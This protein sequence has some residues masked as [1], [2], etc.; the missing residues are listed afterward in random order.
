[1]PLRQEW[2]DWEP[3]YEGVEGQQLCAGRGSLTRLPYGTDLIHGRTEAPGVES[4][5]GSETGKGEMLEES[6]PSL[7][8]EEGLGPGELLLVTSPWVLGPQKGKESPSFSCP[9][10]HLILSCPHH[11]ESSSS[12]NGLFCF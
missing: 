5:P 9:V 10:W 4:V 11:H 1:M 6:A 3:L 2:S 7:K 12:R 8:E